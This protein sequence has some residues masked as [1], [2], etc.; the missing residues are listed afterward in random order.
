MVD[1]G[2]KMLDQWLHTKVVAA[3]R[4]IEVT[5]FFC[6]IILLKDKYENTNDMENSKIKDFEGINKIL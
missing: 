2:L 3:T 5:P 1:K 4:N 6:N